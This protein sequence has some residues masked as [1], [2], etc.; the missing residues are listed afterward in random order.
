M[1]IIKYI[2]ILLLLL[3]IFILTKKIINKKTNIENYD[4]RISDIGAI[5]KCGNNCS[6]IYG[7]G[8]FA[9]NKNLDK[10]YLSKFPIT[11][12]PIPSLYSNEYSQNNIYCNKMF[13]INT[14]FAIN[15]DMYVDNKIYD[16]YTEKADYI[17]KKYYDF[18][19]PG[20]TIYF[21]DIYTIKSDPYKISN[22]V[23]PTDKKDIKFDSKFNV[24][25]DANEIVYEGDQFNEYSGEFLNPSQCKTETPI[26]D[27]LSNC[28]KNAD[29]VGVE[30][31][32][33]YNN[34]KNVC[35][36]MSTIGEKIPR[37]EDSE[38]GIFY[39]KIITNIQ[40]LNKNNI[41]F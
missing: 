35:C 29:C 13:P 12:P 25:Y 27:C 16:C 2:I 10:C 38:N 6:S 31:N 8:G 40:N 24:I 22:L 28:T 7:C 3:I 20:R 41:I 21:N 14:D 23:W 15:N 26:S 5:E 37:G 11:A 34:Y 17:G 4:A 33:N 18:G 39:K 1:L 36:P 32:L 19:K 30:Y 9:Y